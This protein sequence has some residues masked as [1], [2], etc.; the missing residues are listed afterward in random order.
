MAEPP[1]PEKRAVRRSFERAA[2]TYDGNNV[3]QCEVGLRLM[4][5]LDPIR[6]EP[7]R[8]VDVGC[9]TGMFLEHLAK[10]FP[11]AEIVGVDIVAQARHY[12]PQERL[13]SPRG[14]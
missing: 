11:K 8:I 1:I 5:H 7:T 6:I 9:G 12:A 13:E 14:S 2:A 10:R 3:L 4:K